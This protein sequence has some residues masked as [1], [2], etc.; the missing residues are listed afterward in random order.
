[1][2]SILSSVIDESAEKIFMFD[3]GF[4]MKKQYKF[5]ESNVIGS[6]LDD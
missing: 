4:M 3:S 5:L 6:I 2:L 1:L